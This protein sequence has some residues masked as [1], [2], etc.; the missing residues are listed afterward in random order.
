MYPKPFAL[1][2]LASHSMAPSPPPAVALPSV[3]SRDQR[4]ANRSATSLAPATE[5]HKP[6]S[7]SRKRQQ[8]NADESVNKRN[9]TVAD[10]DDDANEAAIA[11]EEA[12]EG[13]KG[14][15]KAK[16]AKKTGKKRYLICFFYAFFNFNIFATSSK[17]TWTDRQREDEAE[18]AKGSPIHLQPYV[19]L[20]FIF[21]N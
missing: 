15:R 12:F 3:T 20:P 6:K 5:S 1:G 17:K 10:D 8:S 19:P 16:K 4:A 21:F 7:T 2:V 9:K 18:K 13:P 14:G 11:I